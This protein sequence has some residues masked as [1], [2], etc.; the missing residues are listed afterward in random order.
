ME[1]L[2]VTHIGHSLNG[3]FQA[4]LGLIQ[5]FSE[6]AMVLGVHATI[7]GAAVRPFSRYLEV[8]ISRGL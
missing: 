1:P 4:E 8:F 6:V 3:R 7:S 2:G 5:N